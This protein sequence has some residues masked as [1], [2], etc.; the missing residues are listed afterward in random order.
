MRKNFFPANLNKITKVVVVGQS[1][2]NL[3]DTR[4][5]NWNKV[6]NVCIGAKDCEQKQAKPETGR[7]LRIC[8][9]S[10][11]YGKRIVKFA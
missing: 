2:V 3:R 4:N 10:T 9:K 8:I 1:Y 7:K 11:S 5:L 6:Q